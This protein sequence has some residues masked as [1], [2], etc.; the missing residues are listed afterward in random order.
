MTFSAD[1]VAFPAFSCCYSCCCPCCCSCCCF[2]AALAA[3]LS[4]I[5]ISAHCWYFS[6]ALAATCAAAL[7]ATPTVT[8]DAA[9]VTVAGSLKIDYV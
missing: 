4:A 8:L 3:I 6:G 7:A 2:P 5:L 9:S 1:N